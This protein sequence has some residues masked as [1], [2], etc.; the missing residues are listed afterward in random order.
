MIEAYVLGRPIP[1]S[2]SVLTSVASVSRAGGVVW[3]SSASIDFARAS[4]PSLTG[5]RIVSLSLSAASGSSD[6]STYARKN[7]WK[8]M[9]LPFA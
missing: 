5:G 2:S 8:S 9:T 7:P 3:C 1:S 6:P 4:S